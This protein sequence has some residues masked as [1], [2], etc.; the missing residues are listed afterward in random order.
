MACKAGTDHSSH[1][2]IS[3]ETAS[4]DF[5]GDTKNIARAM[6]KKARGSIRHLDNF[7]MIYE[8]NRSI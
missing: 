5:L 4:T 6:D 3:A 1:T 2:A 8:W 7:V